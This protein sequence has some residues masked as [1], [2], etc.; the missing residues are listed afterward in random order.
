MHVLTEVN[1][2]DYLFAIR[3]CTVDTTFY[4]NPTLFDIVMNIYTGG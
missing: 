2:F 1:D 3:R 4:E